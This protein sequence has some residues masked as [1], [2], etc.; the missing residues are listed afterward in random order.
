MGIKHIYTFLSV[1]EGMITTL[2]ISMESHSVCQAS[3]R[4]LLIRGSAFNR[5]CLDR[6]K[7]KV[8]LLC[9]EQMNIVRDVSWQLANGSIYVDGADTPTH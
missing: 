2:Y 6:E 1:A 3:T 4:H 5:V 7:I 9:S 8:M